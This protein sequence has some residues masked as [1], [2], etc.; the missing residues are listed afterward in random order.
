MIF[1]MAMTDPEQERQR[2]VEFYSSKPDVELEQVTEEADGLTDIAREALRAEL[3]KR[4][5][6]IGQ[7]DDRALDE[8]SAEFRNLVV[9][10]TFWN[11][12]EAELAKGLLDSAGVEAFLFDDN[13]V[14][15]DWFNANALGG[16]KLRVDASNVEA[17]N[18]IL[19][20]SV[21]DAA[22]AEEADST[23]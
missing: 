11:L 17:A 5:L 12:L 7:L 14:R 2:L 1:A 3:T 20:E 15:L 6:Y 8:E 4:G 13:M 23:D 21:S 19:N 18:R 9:I 22:A 16:V 10:R